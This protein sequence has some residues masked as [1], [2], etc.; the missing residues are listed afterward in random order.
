MKRRIGQ[1]SAAACPLKPVK[2]PYWTATEY[3][4]EYKDEYDNENKIASS[5]ST[6]P[7]RTRTRRRSRA[8]NC[9]LHNIEEA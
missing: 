1:P 9:S 4:D 5:R 8:R 3:E 7:I 6:F 2:R